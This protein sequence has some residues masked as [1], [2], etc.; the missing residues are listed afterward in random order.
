MFQEQSHVRVLTRAAA[1]TSPRCWAGWTDA[2]WT[3]AVN[4]DR[5]YAQADLHADEVG[6]DFAGASTTCCYAPTKPTKSLSGLS[7]AARPC[8]RPGFE[9]PP[10]VAGN[11]IQLAPHTRMCHN[12]RGGRWP[13]GGPQVTNA[14]RPLAS[15]PAWPTGQV[16]GALYA[17][18]SPLASRSPLGTTSSRDVR[19][20]ATSHPAAGMSELV[21][22]AV[23]RSKPNLPK[24]L[25]RS[26][27]TRFRPR[28][29]VVFASCWGAAG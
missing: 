27:R 16:S 18:S 9:K 26:A 8:R 19:P 11:V 13:L 14:V 21:C 4:R 7:H 25:E 22:P 2:G 5:I 12:A 10:C 24:T 15:C 1:S 20:I 6:G 3:A 23:D 29:G 17:L 28:P